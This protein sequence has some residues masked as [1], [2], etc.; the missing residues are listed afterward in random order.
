MIPGFLVKAVVEVPLGAHP[1]AC[2]K[3]YDYDWE[4]IEQYAQE[5]KD[6]AK[7]Q[8]YLDR[9]VYNVEELHS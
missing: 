3:Y 9:Y 6:P 5:A 2:Y 1:Y 4:R 7:F 8:K